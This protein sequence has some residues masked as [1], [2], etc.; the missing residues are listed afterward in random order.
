MQGV[1]LTLYSIKKLKI[2]QGTT[3]SCRSI[4]NDDDDAGQY[5]GWS[6]LT[7]V[8]V[9]FIDLRGIRG[10]QIMKNSVVTKLCSV[11]Q[12]DECS[13]HRKD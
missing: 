3:K 6:S 13:T 5:S 12:S 7:I 2:G 11:S 10:I 8:A 9:E 1:L 4:D